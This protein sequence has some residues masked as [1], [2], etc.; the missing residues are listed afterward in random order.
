MDANV[1]AKYTLQSPKS[2]K[3]LLSLLLPTLLSSLPY[4]PRVGIT[5]RSVG[6]PQPTQD[7]VD[8]VPAYPPGS[9]AL[10]CLSRKELA[11]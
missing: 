2:K 8:R 7:G 4:L 5:G 11:N 1:T 3:W 9:T 10:T 6:R